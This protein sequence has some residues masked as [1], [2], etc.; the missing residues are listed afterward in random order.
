MRLAAAF[1]L[2][3]LGWAVLADAPP[4]PPQQRAT[5]PPTW[6][7]TFTPTASKTPTVT[8]TPT[9]TPTLTREQV[10]AEFVVLDLSG[11]KR[12][13]PYTDTFGVLFRTPVDGVTASFFAFHRLSGI[14][15]G[16]EDIERVDTN[17]INVP[18]AML[19]RH[20]LYDWR[21]ELVD[22]GG[23]VL[24]E[25]GGSFVAGFP[26]TATPTPTPNPNVTVIT[27]TPVV[28]IVTA[29]PEPSPTPPPE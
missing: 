29:T 10:C 9:I 21:L 25:L 8:P 5:L 17:A 2:L 1:L 12:Y 22:A 14:G 24:C 26:V 15:V 11:G 13:Y 4:P 27:T 28:I 18:I 7:P 23:T 19:P 6:T 3:V 16:V 20:G